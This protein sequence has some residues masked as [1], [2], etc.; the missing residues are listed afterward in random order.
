VRSSGKLTFAWAFA[1]G[2]GAG[3][4]AVSLTVVAVI[5][6]VSTLFSAVWLQAQKL[7]IEAETSAVPILMVILKMRNRDNSGSF[8]SQ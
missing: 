1:V 5:S 3:V 2:E 4:D 6:F 8:V 7:S